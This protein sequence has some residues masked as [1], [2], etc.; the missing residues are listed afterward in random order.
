MVLRHVRHAFMVFRLVAP[1]CPLLQVCAL[2]GRPEEESIPPPPLAVPSPPSSLNGSQ[3]RALFS[4]LAL[5][6]IHTRIPSC[7]CSLMG[8]RMAPLQGTPLP[9]PL[10]VWRTA[11]GAARPVQLQPSR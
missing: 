1:P 8:P 9:P 5:L 10:L 4:S 3:A 2:C 11:P 7:R 6:Y